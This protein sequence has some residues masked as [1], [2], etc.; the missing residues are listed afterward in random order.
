M[1]ILAIIPARGGSKSIPRKNI[2]ELAGRPLLEYTAEAAL[3]SQSLS[4]VVLSTED[5]EIREI[6][7]FGV[8]GCP[9]IGKYDA[10][11]ACLHGHEVSHLSTF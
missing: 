1:N 9:R 8:P 5:K 2:R 6:E 4:R 10:R 7:A 11:A 3:Q